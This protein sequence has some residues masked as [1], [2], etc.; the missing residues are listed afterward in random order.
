MVTLNGEIEDAGANSR[1]RI[2]EELD[3]LAG[4]IPGLSQIEWQADNAFKARMK[5]KLPVGMMQSRIS[6]E[7]SREDGALAVQINGKVTNVAGG[8]EARVTLTQQK[9]RFSY[10]LT[11]QF[12]GWLASLGEGLLKPIMASRAREFEKNFAGLIAADSSQ[13]GT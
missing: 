11:A 6:G 10:E 2:F 13:E 3:E 9:D 12:S 7:V 1:D 8:F 5:L 4:T